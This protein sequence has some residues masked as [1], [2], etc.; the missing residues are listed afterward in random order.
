MSQR[1]PNCFS[2]SLANTF[3]KGSVCHR[4][5]SESQMHSNSSSRWI[6]FCKI[7]SLKS[8]KEKLQIRVAE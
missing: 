2:N 5:N 8:C 3:N 4:D 7:P 1:N 6:Q